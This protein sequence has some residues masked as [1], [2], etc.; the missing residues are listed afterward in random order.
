MRKAFG[1]LVALLIS[2]L[3]LIS[4]SAV[5][6]WYYAQSIQ[7]SEHA[8]NED[9]ILDHPDGFHATLGENPSTLGWIRV[10]LGAGNGVPPKHEFTVFARFGG[11]TEEY[12]VGMS[13]DLFSEV[14]VGEGDDSDDHVFYAPSTGTSWRYII[15][16]GKSGS[17]S[18][19]DPIYGP[20]ID[21]VGWESP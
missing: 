19:S 1:I 20:E 16:S 11:E 7:D 21:A 13:E 12:T 17:T 10:D 8:T 14:S 3:I 5:A 18:I 6:A 4:S 9:E 2:I 15:L